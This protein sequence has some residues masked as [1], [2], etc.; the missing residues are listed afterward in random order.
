MAI[1]TRTPTRAALY[2]RISEDMTGEAA[3]VDRQLHDARALAAAR[4]W[5]VVAEFS[6]NSISALNGRHR[7]GYEHLMSQARG[8]K[9]DRIVVFHSSRLWRN[10][11]ERARDIDALAKMRVGIIAVKGPDLDLSTAYGRGLAGLLGEFDTMESEV[12]GERVTAAAADRAR[13]GRPNGALGYGWTRVEGSEGRPT[14][15]EHL[16]QA[17]V[18]REITDRL[19]RGEALRAVTE[20]LNTAG[21]A[22]PGVALSFRNKARGNGNEDGARWSKSSVK[23]LALRAS[24]A[25]LRVHHRG[26]D[27][28]Q[29]Y[30]GDWPTLVPRDR[31]EALRSLLTAPERGVA[32]PGSRKHLLT[33]GI[34]CCG[35]CGSVLRTA[36][37]GS[38]THGSKAR[39]YLCEAKACVG[40]NEASVDALVAEVVIERL[41]RPDALDW[42]AGDDQRAAEAAERVRGLTARL[43]DVADR[44]AEGKVTIAQLER[45]TGQLRPKIEAAEEER[46][47]HRG[48]VDLQTLADLAA[49]MAR[50]RWATLA[51]AQR[52]AVLEALGVVVCIDRVARRGPGFD[53]HSVKIGWRQS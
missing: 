4:G 43:A 26:K 45:I 50:E 13:K 40:R 8:G 37:K 44:Y 35:V 5:E 34:G 49:P 39:L 6:D 30:E 42:L 27:D 3:G 17:V 24:N 25:G 9:L 33:S 36:M 32:R 16:E 51:V 20:H 7:P 29:V 19:L 46:R 1:M 52:R 38:A 2:A 47:E 18:V 15:F 41:S 21:I 28:E 10:R 14:Y 53:P 31:W 23:K 11:R 48:A 22:P 12:K